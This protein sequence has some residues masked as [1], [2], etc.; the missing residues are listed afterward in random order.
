MREAGGREQDSSKIS[1]DEDGGLQLSWGPVWSCQRSRSEVSW[2]QEARAISSLTE[3]ARAVMA[4][5]ATHNV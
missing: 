3:L 2:E 5:E 1:V 4:H